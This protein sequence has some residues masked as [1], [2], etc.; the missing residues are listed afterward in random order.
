MWVSKSAGC[1]KHIN[2]DPLVGCEV[3]SANCSTGFFFVETVLWFNCI[4][5]SSCTFQMHI[6]F[7]MGRIRI[8][9]YLY[10]FIYFHQKFLHKRRLGFIEPI[11]LAEILYKY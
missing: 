7:K 11:Q 6:S 10:F 9:L 1:Y 5:L 4:D 2:N 8:F 3:L